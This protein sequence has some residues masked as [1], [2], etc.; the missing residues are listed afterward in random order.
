M[1]LCPLDALDIYKHSFDWLRLTV[2]VEY[3]KVKDGFRV[4]VIRRNCNIVIWSFSYISLDFLDIVA[5][6][7]LIK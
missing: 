5:V 7:V 1:V 6:P 4:V 2:E 3:F